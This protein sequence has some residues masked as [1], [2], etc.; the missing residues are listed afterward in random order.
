M[1]LNFNIIFC[2]KYNDCQIE[3][4]KYL[5]KYSNTSYYFCDFA[6]INDKFDCIVSPG[7]SYGLMDGGMD[8][9]INRYFS[10]VDNF[11]QNIQ[12]QLLNLCG[13]YQ[14]TGTCTL[15]NTR[16]TKC[17]YIAHCPTMHIPMCINDLNVIYNCYWNLLT[18]IYYHNNNNNNNNKDK[19]KN[20]LC[21]GL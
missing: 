6:D 10:D 19:I 9:A 18:T 16:S 11:I 2:S 1:F 20:V 7:N 21:I 13:G 3:F 17:K 14:Q 4:D 8:G 15:L 12:Q 5:K